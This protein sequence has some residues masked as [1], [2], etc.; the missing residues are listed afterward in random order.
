[1]QVVGKEKIMKLE[2]FR[3]DLLKKLENYKSFKELAGLEEKMREVEEIKKFLKENKHLGKLKKVY[4]DRKKSLEMEILGIVNPRAYENQ[5][6][7]TE[8]FVKSGLF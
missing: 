3:E 1:V 2:N 6:Q 8:G 7:G 5:M 4:V